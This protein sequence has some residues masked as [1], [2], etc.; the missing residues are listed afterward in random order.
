MA[1]KGRDEG[2]DSGKDEDGDKGGVEGGDEEGGKGEVE[3][4]DG[5]GSEGGSDFSVKKSFRM[6]MD[7]GRVRLRRSGGAKKNSGDTLTLT[8]N[9]SFW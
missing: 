2:V 9:V 4:A 5:K 3:E 7:E 6:V 8:C 1:D